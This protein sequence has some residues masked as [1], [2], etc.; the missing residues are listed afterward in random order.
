VHDGVPFARKGE[1][2][3]TLPKMDIPV[4]LVEWELFVPDAYTITGSDGN[5]MSRALAPIPGVTGVG[6]AG[7]F[8][9]RLGSVA[10]GV[11]GG[12]VGGVATGVAG[13]VAEAPTPPPPPAAAPA[14]AR[15]AMEANTPQVSQNVLDLQRRAAGVLPIKID[16]P[17]VGTSHQFV[18][19]LLV[20]DV[21]SVKLQYKARKGR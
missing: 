19:P 4:G 18:K 9:S 8:D 15:L 21:A 3:M 7:R 16:V 1:L 2:Q 11:S 17:R 12:V 14:A 13:G 20:D 5:V 10:G 6:L